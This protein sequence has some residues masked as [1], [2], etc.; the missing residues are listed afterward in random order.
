M[1]GRSMN[2]GNVRYRLSSPTDRRAFV[3]SKY[4]EGVRICV[5]SEITPEPVVSAKAYIGEN[6]DE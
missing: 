6:V 2:M 3:D 4:V 5:G 1:K